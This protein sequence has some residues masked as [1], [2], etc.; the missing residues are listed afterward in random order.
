MLMQNSDLLKNG[1]KFREAN[2]CIQ[3]EQQKCKLLQRIKIP[4]A[5]KQKKNEKRTNLF[6]M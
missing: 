5:Y 1:P 3:S 4:R 2:E 6:I